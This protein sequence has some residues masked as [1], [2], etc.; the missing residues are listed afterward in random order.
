MDTV[1]SVGFDLVILDAF[2]STVI[3]VDVENNRT[4]RDMLRG[5]LEG[6]NP[7]MEK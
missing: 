7:E 4:R 6:R 5:V 3:H 1:F 2:S